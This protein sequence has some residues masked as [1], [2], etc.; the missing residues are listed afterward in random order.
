M[1]KKYL[2]AISFIIFS[3]FLYGCDYF[4]PGM[5][6]YDYHLTGSYHLYKAGEARIHTCDHSSKQAVEGNVT[7][8]A[9]DEDFIL[10]EQTKDSNTNYWIIDVKNDKVYSPTS[11]KDFNEK[12]KELKVNS[13][14]KLK[15]P[16]TFKHL[17]T[18]PMN[19]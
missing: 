18:S 12:R 4:G 11:E 3:C 1:I 5:A 16:E 8:I 19:K 15:K 2:L 6:D 10:A 9:W 14:L 7:G 13:K 17:D